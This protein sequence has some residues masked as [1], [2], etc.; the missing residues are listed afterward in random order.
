MAAHDYQVIDASDPRSPIV[1]ANIQLVQQKIENN[2]TGTV[3]LLG[4]DGLTVLRR[5][6]REEEYRATQLR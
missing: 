2:D 5:P 3:F 1:L 6:H 4:A